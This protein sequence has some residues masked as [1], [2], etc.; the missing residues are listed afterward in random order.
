MRRKQMQPLVRRGEELTTTSALVAR[1]RG[2]AAVRIEETLAE[3]PATIRRLRTLLLVM[4]V[5]VPV[6]LVAI[7]VVLWRLVS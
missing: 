1:L 3:V 6:F 5:S 4:S 7:V 2:M